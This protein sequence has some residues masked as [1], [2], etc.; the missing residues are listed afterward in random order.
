MPVPLYQQ[1]RDAYATTLLT[2][3][4]LDAAVN[5]VR[6]IPIIVTENDGEVYIDKIPEGFLPENAE[7]RNAGGAFIDCQLHLAFTSSGKNSR[8]GLEEGSRLDNSQ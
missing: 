6:K 2:R 8:W 1:I 4:G 5:P 3:N 7:G